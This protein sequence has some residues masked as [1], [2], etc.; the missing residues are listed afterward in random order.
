MGKKNIKKI[1]K[2]L[3]DYREL[4]PG[5]KV[6]CTVIKMGEKNIKKKKK[7]YAFTES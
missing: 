6:H 3:C 4:N 1:N 2:K 7:N 5:S